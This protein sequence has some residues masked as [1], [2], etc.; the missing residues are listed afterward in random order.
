M[1]PSVPS[2]TPTTVN[3]KPF[4]RVLVGPISTSADQAAVLAQVQKLGYKDAF[5]A[6]K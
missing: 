5:L 6:A 4:W 1:V 3:G 2:V